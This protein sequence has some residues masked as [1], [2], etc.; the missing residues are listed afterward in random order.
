VQIARFLPSLCPGTKGQG[1][2]KRIADGGYGMSTLPRQDWQCP[3]CGR[4]YA[5]FVMMCQECKPKKPEADP[6]RAVDALRDKVIDKTQEKMDD[7]IDAL[8][9]RQGEPEGMK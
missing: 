5:P 8:F 9:S 7:A 1:K 4:V 6:Q 2:E 3:V